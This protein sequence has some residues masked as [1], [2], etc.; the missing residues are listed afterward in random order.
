M[1]R[2]EILFRKPPFLDFSAAFFDILRSNPVISPLSVGAS[3]LT[4][5]QLLVDLQLL[6][7][8]L[9]CLFS[10]KDSERG[11]VGRVDDERGL[12]AAVFARDGWGDGD[13]FTDLDCR[14]MLVP[15]EQ[16]LLLEADV[17]AGCFL[18][19][20]EGLCLSRESFLPRESFL[21]FAFFMLL[22]CSS[23]ERQ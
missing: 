22:E 16:D 11:R 7:L 12:G 21:A 17:D 14:D 4:D 8:L 15:S 3:L 10:L 6:R 23:R 19:A 5:L 18:A 20:A 13:L 2:A 9:R 1:D